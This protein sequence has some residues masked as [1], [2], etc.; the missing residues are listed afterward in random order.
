MSQPGCTV[1][2]CTYNRLESLKRSLASLLALD[3]SEYEIVIIND[4]STD[5]TAKYLETL[6]DSKIKIVTHPK[7]LGLS[8]AR[9]S[10]IK[11]AKYDF[12]ASIDD[13]C[14]ADKFWLKNLMAGFTSEDISFVF[15]QVFYISENYHGYFPERLVKN[16]GAMW[17]M[18]GNIV[19][20]KKVFEKIG[21]LNSDFF[22][23]NNEDSEIAI[24]AVANGF[25]YAR[26]PQAII[27]HEAAV[28]NIKSLLRSARNGAVWPKLKKL[29][30]KH[31]LEFN[32]KVW[33]G[34]VVLPWD[35]LYILTMPICILVL[36]MRYLM[37]GKRDFKI[38][39]AKWPVLLL[40]RRYYI[41][42]EA[43][44]NQVLMF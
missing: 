19:Y 2:L 28:W 18:G 12:V 40:L 8:E 3:Y 26:T 29:Y 27:I 36:L 34:L 7:N 17:P 32:P 44:K 23:F 14:V 35:Y 4:A 30:P 24:R 1:T 10:G 15:G 38:F 42:K 21:Y 22:Y 43:I 37:H 5:G 25:K 9:N 6:K 13:D 16:I 11:S 41:W 39:F 33:R 31:Y 20:R